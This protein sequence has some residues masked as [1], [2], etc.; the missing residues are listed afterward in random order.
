MIEE[1]NRRRLQIAYVL[2]ASGLLVYGAADIVAGSFL[3]GFLWY[4]PVG[5]VVALII[6]VG[7]SVGRRG[8]PA[9]VLGGVISA[10]MAAL[11]ALSPWPI[12]LPGGE[13]WWWPLLAVSIVA[14]AIAFRSLQPAWSAT[15][16]V[17]GP[18]TASAG[19]PEP[20][21]RLT[22]RFRR[23]VVAAQVM[24]AAYLVG[25][26]GDV[27]SSQYEMPGLGLPLLIVP[28]VAVLIAAAAYW[29]GVRW[30]AFL[31]NL[32]FLLFAVLW[33]LQ[34]DLTQGVGLL[35]LVGALAAFSA[36]AA[37]LPPRPAPLTRPTIPS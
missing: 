30:P 34:S 27:M 11:G 36:L 16:E 25:A 29:S 33:V 9:L 32:A 10:A 13:R 26:I 24:L 28:L 6:A 3:W 20:A 18:V 19:V 37:L 12:V 35:P 23:T 15:A 1:L 21:S 4:L 22:P 31:I 14:L 2:V 5:I 8:T 17:L 7:L